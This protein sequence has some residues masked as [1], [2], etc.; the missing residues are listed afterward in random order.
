MAGKEARP[1]EGAPVATATAQ[2]PMFPLLQECWG[3]SCLPW[4]GRRAAKRETELSWLRKLC[5]WGPPPRL[6]AEARRQLGLSGGALQKGPGSVRGVCVSQ[7]DRV[8]LLRPPS[9]WG[10]LPVRAG[11]MPLGFLQHWRDG[12]PC[13]PPAAWAKS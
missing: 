6:H 13:T 12:A 7:V 3:G 4:R 10:M 5:L 1:V 2:H 9:T 8:A 11:R